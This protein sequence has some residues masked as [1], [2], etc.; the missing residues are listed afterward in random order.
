VPNQCEVLEH[1]ELIGGRTPD[2]EHRVEQVLVEEEEWILMRLCQCDP[3]RAEAIAKCV[4]LRAA[5]AGRDETEAFYGRRNVLQVQKG[6][7]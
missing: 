5:P 1:Y 7:L 4:T 3:V 2:S 6:S